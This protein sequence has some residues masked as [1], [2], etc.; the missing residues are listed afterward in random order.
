[1]EDTNGNV[2]YYG[3]NIHG[4]IVELYDEDGEYVR[5]Y[6]YDAF[7]NQKTS[8]PGDTNPFRYAGEYYD[9]ETGLIY[10][11]NRYYDT[12]TGR[13]ITE[14]P[15]RDGL[16]WYVYCENNPVMFVDPSG[17]KDYVVV[18]A[19]GINSNASNDGFS[20]LK[21]E[22]TSRI[23]NSGDKVRFVEAFPY[24]EGKDTAIVGQ[25]KAVLNDTKEESNAGGNHVNWKITEANIQ[26]NELIIMIGHSGGGVAVIDAYY[27]MVTDYKEKVRQVVAIGSPKMPINLGKHKT[28]VI[29]DPDDAIPKFGT[30]PGR[31][32]T[33]YSYTVDN[34]VIRWRVPV[35]GKKTALLD[36]ALYVKYAA[37]DVHTSYFDDAD[38]ASNIL[39]QFWDRAV[40]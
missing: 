6:R 3:K 5:D 10:L 9:K 2:Y 11:R 13:F 21:N 14:D 22:I 15:I 39:D 32:E 25:A 18:L 1:M 38:K 37:V 40:E 29:T 12:R 26:D 33:E 27:S 34:D 17:L 8:N 30:S 24:G 16:N 19:H 23:E 7:G 36:A 31:N 35:I 20:H 28:T 4:D